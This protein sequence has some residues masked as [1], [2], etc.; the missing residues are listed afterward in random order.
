MDIVDVLLYSVDPETE[1]IYIDGL[2]GLQVDRNVS[3]LPVHFTLL[4]ML[5]HLSCEY[6]RKFGVE[7]GP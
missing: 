7:P 6:A 4:N 1:S 5:M 2:N 3:H